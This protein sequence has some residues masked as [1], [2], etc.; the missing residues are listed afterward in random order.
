M[1]GGT[2]SG[3]VIDLQQ[4]RTVAN[5]LFQGHGSALEKPRESAPGLTLEPL[6]P[7]AL[8]IAQDALARVSFQ[9]PDDPHPTLPWADTVPGA[10]AVSA[11][12][13]PS[14]IP[15]LIPDHLNPSLFVAM[16]NALF[17]PSFI[18][19]RSAESRPIAEAQPARRIEAARA[20]FPA[21]QQ[22][23][24]GKP[25][26]WLD[27]AATT[28]KPRAVVERI[29]RFYYEENSNVHRGAHLLAARATDAYE[30]ARNQVAR[31]IGAASPQEIVFTRGTTDAINLV[32]ASFGRLRIGPG[33]EII[34]GELE[35]H[36]NIVPWQM[37]AEQQG[38]RIRVAPVD[39][40]GDLLLEQY[41]AL[42]NART[43]LVAMSHVSNAIGTVFPIAQVIAMAH[44]AGARVLI[45]GAQ[46]VPHMAVNVQLLGCDFYCFSGHKLYGPTGIGVLFGRRELLDAMPPYQ[47]GGSMI[48]SVTFE[49]SVY[50]PVPAK[51]EAGTGILAGA[52]G[53]GAAVEYVQQLGLPLIE[54][55]EGALM[56]R[57]L[58]GLS[59]L[60]RIRVIGNP[61]H[62]AG[63]ISF[64]V[65]GMDVATVGMLLDREGI[66][67]RAGHHC[68]QPALAHF[69][70]KATVR[71]SFA[72]YNTHADV[73][74]L[75][76][77][78]HRIVG[79]RG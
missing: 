55:H 13:S 5:S 38:A 60:P 32:A 72:L 12:T 65:D 49:Q 41:G 4:V 50:A 20:D 61:Q 76:A 42:L 34:L 11:K 64:I 48:D 63:A 78:L 24:H 10:G 2:G 21:L 23:V 56:D 15:D 71:P 9:Q 36:S 19:G 51:F 74:T 22:A 47:G 27:N 28:Q 73:D 29:S 69:G 67:V 40:N 18:V 31:F 17:P 54:R 39:D 45:D 7:D 1:A 77:A 52:V 46:S 58:A 30:N 57:T 8:A 14:L 16:A 68:A 37:L 44:H 53:L 70:L 25:L 43:R 62:R 3:S 79:A 33:D 26:V 66:A 6:G 75:L 59:A 35:H